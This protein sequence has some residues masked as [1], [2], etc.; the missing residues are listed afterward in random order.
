M[1]DDAHRL[2]AVA[3]QFAALHAL[4]RIGERILISALGHGMALDAHAQAGVFHHGKHIG[5]AFAGAADQ[6][7]FGFVKLHHASGAG[8][9][10]E[11]VL[12]PHHAHRVA[13][14][15]AAIS[16][17]QIFGHDKH[18]NALHARRRIGQ[19]RQHQMNNIFGDFLRA[20]GDEDFLA[21]DGI[22]AV[23]FGHGL[24]RHLRQ[25]SARARLGEVHGAA[26]SAFTHF[27]QVNLFLLIV[28]MVEQSFNRAD[29]EHGQKRER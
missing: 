22:S 29:G 9:D 1:V 7:A 19:A 6:I 5:Q 27:G 2:L 4:L 13:R 21:A 25:I 28:G 24:H 18:R 17:H 8:V 23:V 16:V 11:L 20:P 10:A 26:P 12:Q 15:E 3:A 14:A